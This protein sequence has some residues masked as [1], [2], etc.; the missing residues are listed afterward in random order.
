MRINIYTIEINEKFKF[1]K[2]VAMSHNVRK[3]VAS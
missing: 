1:K 3:Q 2:G